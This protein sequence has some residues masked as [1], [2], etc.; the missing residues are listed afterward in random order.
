VAFDPR[1]LDLEKEPSLKKIKSPYILRLLLSLDFFLPKLPQK[2]ASFIKYPGLDLGVADAWTH[3]EPMPHR[4]W[5]YWQIHRIFGTIIVI[6]AFPA[7][8]KLIQNLIEG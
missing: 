3:P 6:A 8:I 7:I 4:L 2:V 5:L 1:Y